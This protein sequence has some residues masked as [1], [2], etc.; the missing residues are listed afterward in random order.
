MAQDLN[1]SVSGWI[2]RVIIQGDFNRELEEAI[3]ASNFIVERAY[4]KEA[5]VNFGDLRRHAMSMSIIV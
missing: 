3:Q 2:S 1:V 5:P 4:K